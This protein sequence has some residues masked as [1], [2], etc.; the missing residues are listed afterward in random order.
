MKSRLAGVSMMMLLLCV[1]VVFG[2]DAKPNF[3]G[4]WALDRDKS[5]LGERAG[6]GGGGRGMGMM[7]SVI[8]T[9]DGD[10]LVLKRKIDFQGEER[11]IESRHTTDGKENVN[12]GFRG[13]SVKSKSHWEGAK[14]VTESLMETPNGKRETKE[15]R[16]LSAD[17]KTMTVETTSKGGFGE[18]TRKLVYSKKD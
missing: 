4:A 10:A 15:V 12:E 6:G 13:S 9:H 2:Q 17:G 11:T 14:L 7:G 1:A 16:T 5:E 8:V 3:S 18:G